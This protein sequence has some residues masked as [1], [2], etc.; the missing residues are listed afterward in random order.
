VQPTSD[1]QSGLLTEKQIK[2]F[3]NLSIPWQRRTRREGRGPR[4]LK[5]GKMVRYRQADIEE[6][7]AA[8]TVEP[9]PERKSS[10]NKKAADSRSAATREVRGVHATTH[11]T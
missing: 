1:N 8:H 10:G 3:Y 6:F 9:R 4:F 7:L 5:V 2:D 11:R